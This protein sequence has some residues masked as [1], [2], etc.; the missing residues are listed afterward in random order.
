M[1]AEL[2]ALML[3]G[4]IILLL[5][6]GVE[7]AVAIG[8]VAAFGLLFFIDR[9]LIQFI[10]SGWDTM[11]SF[12][13]TAIPLFIFMGVIFANSGVIRHLF[14]AINKLLGRI[15]G[16]VACSIVGSNAVFGAMCG[17][18]I[19]ATA[20]FGKIA[21]PEAERLGYNPSIV[22][23][24]VAVG[25]ALSALIPPSVL[26]I[27]YGAWEN[28]SVPRLF[29][30]GMIPGI[31][32]L[33]LFVMTIVVWV[34]LNPS[35]AP[36]PP[37]LAWRERLSALKGLMPFV[38]VIASVLGVIF[39]GIMTPTEAASMG[40]VFS[41]IITAAYRKMSFSVLKESIWPPVK[42]TA[43]I[44]LVMLSAKVLAQ[45]F[46]YI[47]LTDSFLALMVAL[48]F[49]KYGIFATICLLYIVL[50]MFLDAFSMLVLTLPFVSPIMAELGFSPLWFGVVYVV[51]AEFGVITPPFGLH[52]F[53]LKNVAPKYDITTI[54]IGA[55]PF[56]L[57]YLIIIVLLGAFPQIALWLPSLLY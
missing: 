28:V 38:A 11:S 6:I 55:A 37:K 43:M 35:I 49:G 7:I 31:I 15:P 36:R 2:T 42:I 19:A 23:G 5:V 4:G 8:I 27:V 32:L 30:A 10:Y 9:P 54:V 53:V 33:S 24:S 51:L 25:G 48:P 39:L 13:L 18:S 22:L 21:L 41:I 52:L 45:V 46:Q 14:D 29:A 3:V 47:G 17:S 20:T 34:K 50:G 1:G 44:A 56:F 16:G 12:E 40:V 57:S 26:L